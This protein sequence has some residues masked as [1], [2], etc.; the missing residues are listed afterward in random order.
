MSTYPFSDDSDAFAELYAA[1]Y[2]KQYQYAYHYLRDEFL[3]QDALQE[4]YILV[5][6]NI[7]KLHDTNVFI[8]WLNQINFRVCFKIAKKQLQYHDELQKYGNENYHMLHGESPD[9][10]DEVDRQ[11]EK[12]YIMN[13]VKSLPQQ[14]SQSIILKYY[15]G[16][17]LDEIAA[18]IG[19]SR[20]TVKRHLR[21][22]RYKLQRT[23]KG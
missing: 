3:A 5:F 4:L 12:D 22:G 16:M 17:K 11:V 7:H 9:P 23:L 19:S 18:M 14:E 15:H 10:A 8:A 6:K 13:R 21:N 20:S 2:K 1:T